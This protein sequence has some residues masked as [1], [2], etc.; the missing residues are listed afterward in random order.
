M[1]HKY[2]LPLPTD[3]CCVMTM[4]LESDDSGTQMVQINITIREEIVQWLEDNRISATWSNIMAVDIW[5]ENPE[6]LAAFKL[7]WLGSG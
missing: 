3:Q 6:D 4:D 5:F 1:V 7:T 2:K